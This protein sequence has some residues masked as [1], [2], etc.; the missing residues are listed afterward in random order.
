MH[1]KKSKD[2]NIFS[3]FRILIYIVNMFIRPYNFRARYFFII[4]NSHEDPNCNGG[5]VKT[6]LSFWLL[7][8]LLLR[9]CISASQL[10]VSHP[11]MMH[12]LITW[13]SHKFYIHDKLQT[14]LVSGHKIY[15]SQNLS[16]EC[17]IK[18]L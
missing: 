6:L 15:S 10:K 12:Y 13:S 11:L 18:Q 3:F 14:N 9:I 4:S 7:Y 1:L 8:N 5:W 16:H 17:V 2:L